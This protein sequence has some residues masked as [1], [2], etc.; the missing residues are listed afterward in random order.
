MRRFDVTR[1]DS[2]NAILGFAG[3]HGDVGALETFAA[4]AGNLYGHTTRQVLQQY[5]E[6]LSFIMLSVRRGEGTGPPY[7]FAQQAAAIDAC[8]T[9]DLIDFIILTWASVPPPPPTVTPSVDATEAAG[10][11]AAPPATATTPT[12]RDTVEDPEIATTDEAPPAARPKV[13]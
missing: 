11:D 13:H 2:L 1:F 10:P 12:T 8:S 3:R 5:A 4:A 6:H 7:D 9:A